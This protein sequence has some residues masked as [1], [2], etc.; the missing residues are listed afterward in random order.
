[1]SSES[2]TSADRIPVWIPLATRLYLAF[3][4]VLYGVIGL[5]GL[6]APQWLM[7]LVDM[8][9]N[10]PSSLNE[11]R[12]FFGGQSLVLAA[13]FA[14]AVRPPRWHRPAL[15]LFVALAAAFA[16]S[17]TASLVVDGVP[18]AL[19]LTLLGMECMGTFAGTVL[20]RLGRG[21][22]SCGTDD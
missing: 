18:G 19:N 4:A 12:A 9:A 20:L 1:M 17:R 16:V 13:I 7:G 3:G 21:Q 22:D 15:M 8:S 10:A 11:V 14:A 2:T 5:A 6:L